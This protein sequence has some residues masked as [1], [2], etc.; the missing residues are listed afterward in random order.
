[1][2]AAET[3]RHTPPDLEGS[4]GAL[5]MMHG[6]AEPWLKA[7]ITRQE[8]PYK[9]CDEASNELV[10]HWLERLPEAAFRMSP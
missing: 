9:R 6:I 10:A 4:T 3:R 8:T 1:M 2:Q 7:E 5:A